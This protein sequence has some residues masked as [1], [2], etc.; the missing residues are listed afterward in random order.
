MSYSLSFTPVLANA[1]NFHPWVKTELSFTQWKHCCYYPYK[2]QYR[3][4][5]YDGDKEIAILDRIFED[6]VESDLDFR[7]LIMV[8]EDVHN[9]EVSQ[10]G[11]CPRRVDS[12]RQLFEAMKELHE[13]VYN[14]PYR[15]HRRLPQLSDPSVGGT[16]RSQIG[17]DNRS[18]LSVTEKLYDKLRNKNTLY[19][20]C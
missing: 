6:K 2:R 7:I 1:L 15:R 3:T 18:A 5:R 10:R 8:V 20:H 9:E 14:G 12:A 16:E 11:N 19:Y 4:H 17:F 13:E